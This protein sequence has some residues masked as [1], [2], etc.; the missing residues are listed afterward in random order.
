MRQVLMR[1]EYELWRSGRTFDAENRSYDRST[2]SMARITF[3]LKMSLNPTA[4]HFS[5]AC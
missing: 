2:L 3:W 4:Q 5:I 1:N